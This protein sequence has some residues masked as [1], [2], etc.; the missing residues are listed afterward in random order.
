MM[1]YRGA[2]V[3]YNSW[4]EGERQVDRKPDQAMMHGPRCAVDYN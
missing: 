1:D 2:T 4:G 3:I